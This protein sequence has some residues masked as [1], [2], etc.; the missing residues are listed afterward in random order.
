MSVGLDTALSTRSAASSPCQC[1]FKTSDGY[2]LQFT[3]ASAI[4]AHALVKDRR[5][6][7]R[8]ASE[9]ENAAHG[10]LSSSVCRMT[11][12]MS[13]DHGRRSSSYT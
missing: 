13:L 10:R 5:S 8:S 11:Q 9:K 3:A 4:A 1:C 7:A 2:L 6:R 12:L